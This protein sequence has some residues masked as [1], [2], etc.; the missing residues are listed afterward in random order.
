MVGLWWPNDLTTTSDLAQAWMVGSP[1]EIPMED[2]CFSCNTRKA[3][4]DSDVGLCE[5]CRT[6]LR[7][8]A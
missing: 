3:A 7:S 4:D 6:R 5:P 1:P 8:V 2:R